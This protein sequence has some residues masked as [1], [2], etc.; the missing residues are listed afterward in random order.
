MDI[1]CNI[2]DNYVKY[3]CVMLTSLFE[4]NREEEFTIHILGNELSGN[5]TDTLRK[6]VENKYAG[7]IAFYNVKD[8]E[9]SL[10]TTNAHIS[11][12][13]YYRL[14]MVSLLPSS[15]HK[16]LYLDC[17]LLVVG[18]LRDFWVTDISKYAVGAVEDMWA[19]DHDRG[20]RLGYPS[21]YS[22]FNAGVM[23][24]NLDHWRS[25][26][27]EKL[28]VDFI[29][30]KFDVISDADQDVLNGIFYNQKY[31]VSYRYNLQDGFYRRKRH[32]RLE[33]EEELNRD[34]KHPV[35]VHFTNRRKPWKFDCIHPLKKEYFKYL[36]MTDWKGERPHLSF[37]QTWKLLNYRLSVL[38]HLANGFRKV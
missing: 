26:N 3:C 21:E 9:F 35:I 34:L 30:E 5:T 13:T 7:K 12:A 23:L 4:N 27:F 24:I 36:D 37:R 14:F 32:I 28:A 8:I 2:D 15:L 20:K 18:S 31:F 22:S 17:D 1:V 25:I 38:L 6:L 11:V 10:P 16:V 19:L 33:A 29:R